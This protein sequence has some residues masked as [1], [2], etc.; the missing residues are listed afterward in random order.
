MKIQEVLIA[1]ALA[2]ATTAGLNYFFSRHSGQEQ[3]VA[4]RSG[5]RFTAPKSTEI[6]VHK[7]LN[8]E[9]DFI[10]AKMAK[11]PV[12]TTFE[13]EHARY[14]FSSAG[15]ALQRVEFRRNWGGKQGFLAT[16]FP[17]S[18]GDREQAAFLVALDGET[19]YLFDLIDHQENDQMH[20]LTYKAAI[21]NG[22]LIKKFSVFKNEYRIDLALS[23]ELN[24]GGQERQ[25][26]IF[27][28]SPLV[29]ELIGQDAI[30]LLVNDERNSIKILQK[31][32]EVAS[33]YWSL[34][35]FFGAQDRYFVHAMV[36]D[37]KQFTQRG[38]FKVSD[39]D[40]WYA[41]LEGPSTAVSNS[42]N[43]TFYVGP[44]E[45]QA[46]NA[47]DPR[48]IQTLNYGYFSFISKP[49][50]QLMLRTLE[51]IY[52]HVHNYGWAIIILTIIIKLILLPF[53][54][55]GD[56]SMKKRL[57]FQKK[58]DYVQTKYKHDKE[59]LGMARAE[60]VRKHGMPGMA[61]CLP[62]LLQLP[63][64]WA[65]SIILANSIQLYKAPFL[66]IPD[67]TAQDPYYILPVLMVIAII[68]HSQGVSDTKQRLS[69]VMMAFFVGAVVASF[70]A[71]LG[72]F[73]VVST[74]LG[75]IQA[76]IMKAFGHD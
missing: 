61:G 73:M 5:Q 51:T 3:G 28:P 24:A 26:R 68:L 10:D 39:I 35:T 72:I 53:T 41:I 69:S 18:A 34:P 27:L 42:W 1:L 32:K 46:M 62:L 22:L 55:S 40:T 50:S 67:L 37:P 17:P 21:K 54:W 8:L 57:E 63:I 66:W 4:A 16:I 25:A 43:L 2:L 49:L 7:P 11:V 14:E 59:A 76:Q 33:S 64:F 60:L 75:V 45:D 44:K 20:L 29:P 48:L 65:L 71:G 58:L 23:L 70:S 6:E 31:T 56:K 30:T 38:Y 15:A 9:V 47:V 12:V 74:F 19:P 13:T 36:N 52:D